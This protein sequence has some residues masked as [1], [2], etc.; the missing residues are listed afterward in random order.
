MPLLAKKLRQF[1]L[2]GN[3]E[4]IWYIVLLSSSRSWDINLLVKKMNFWWIIIYISSQNVVNALQ[5]N[6]CST[7]DVNVFFENEQ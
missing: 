3:F 6:D 5:T 7:T 4:Q 1:Q 2:I